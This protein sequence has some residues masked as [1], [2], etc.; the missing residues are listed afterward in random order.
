[1]DLSRCGHTELRQELT[2]KLTREI[3]SGCSKSFPPTSLKPQGPGPGTTTC[4]GITNVGFQQSR[5]LTWLEVVLHTAGSLP[6]ADDKCSDRQAEVSGRQRWR[7][8]RGW[9]LRF[10]FGRIDFEVSTLIST[11]IVYWQNGSLRDDAGGRRSPELS[12]MWRWFNHSHDRIKI[13][14][15]KSKSWTK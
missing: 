12:E 1:M 7:C 5:L 10:H 11:K 3:V 8:W 14:W 2:I 6:N 9:T 4:R 13:Q 15:S